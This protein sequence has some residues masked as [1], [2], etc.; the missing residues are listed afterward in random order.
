MASNL[1]I[2]GRASQ[3][4]NLSGWLSLTACPM[5]SVHPSPH[6]G[7]AFVGEP[8]LQDLAFMVDTVRVCKRLQ[9]DQVAPAVVVSSPQF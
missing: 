1:C 9:H 3:T 4:V 5:C 8:G 6:V 2:L 7:N